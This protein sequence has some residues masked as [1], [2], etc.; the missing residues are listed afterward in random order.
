[1]LRKGFGEMV[2]MPSY[3]PQSHAF[4]LI[5]RTPVHFEGNIAT[6]GRPETP[7]LPCFLALA[8]YG[9]SATDEASLMQRFRSNDARAS[10][11]KPSLLHVLTL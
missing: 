3:N 4:T 6:P 5:N 11:A 8:I 10:T 2:P 7:L 1:M 9:R